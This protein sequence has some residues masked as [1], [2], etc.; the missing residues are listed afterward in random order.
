MD[1]NQVKV[2]IADDEPAI[3]R[4]IANV[5]SAHGYLVEEARNGE[6]AVI[7]VRSRSADIALLDINMPGIGG[8]EACRRIRSSF[9]EM[10][11]IMVTVRDSEQDT[12]AAL[13]SGADD[14]INKPFRAGE[15]LARIN[16][17]LRRAHRANVVPSIIRVGSLVLD[18]VHRVLTKSGQEVHLSP[19]EFNLLHYFMQ[20]RNI[21]LDHSKLLRAVWGPEY[22]NEIEYLRTYIRL[23][24]RKIEDD[25]ANPRYITT[26]PWQGYRFRGPPDSQHNNAAAAPG[27]ATAARQH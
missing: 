26:E 8:M 6:E 2:L 24:R 20:N 23:V 16:A 10:G 19:I 12:V 14:Y 21:P 1:A 22:G 3:R 7:S 17:L 13:E 11:I 15:L 9:P 25:P 18:T 5:L 4:V 27:I